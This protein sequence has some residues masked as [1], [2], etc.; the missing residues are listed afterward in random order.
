MNE[1]EMQRIAFFIKR[2][3]VDDEDPNSVKGDV[4][5]FVE[6]F[7]GIEYCFK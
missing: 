3:V 5:K 1:N 7:Q 4:M 2:V 6:E